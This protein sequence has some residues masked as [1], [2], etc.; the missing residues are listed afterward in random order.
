MISIELK[1]YRL[2]KHTE[3]LLEENEEKLCIKV[4]QTLKEMMTVDINY[5]EKVSKGSEVKGQI[6][7][8]MCWE[9]TYSLKRLLCSERTQ[10][11]IIIFHVL[12]VQ[13]STLLLIIQLMQRI[14]IITNFIDLHVLFPH[15]EDV[16]RPLFYAHPLLAAS[17]E[18]KKRLGSKLTI[19]LLF[20]IER[21]Y[22]QHY[23]SDILVLCLL[24]ASFNYIW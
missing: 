21:K 1:F 14:T 23:L 24:L 4:L 11:S 6:T 8:S 5:G 19:P 15:I 10:R 20:L 2:I 18:E 3:K 7:S 12:Y 13:I 16:N 22:R 9:K 17:F